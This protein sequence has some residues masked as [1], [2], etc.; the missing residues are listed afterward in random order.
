MATE[1]SLTDA[2]M[3][4]RLRQVETDLKELKEERE[5]LLEMLV[6]RGHSTFDDGDEHLTVKVMQRSRMVVNLPRLQLLDPQMYQRITKSVVDTT[7][8]NRSLEAGEWTDPKLMDEVIH[9]VEDRPFLKM[10][11]E[12]HE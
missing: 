9:V 7:A 11:V 2:Q 10:T 3:Y 8:L 6:P 5:A 12:E 1:D 4:I